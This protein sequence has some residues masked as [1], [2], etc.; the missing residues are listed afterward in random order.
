MAMEGDGNDSNYKTN[1]QSE[2]TSVL[3]AM[4]R[5]ALPHL[6]RQQRIRGG[7]KKAA[8]KGERENSLPP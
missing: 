6:R 8:N 4:R 5:V 3:A 1:R 7:Q 2:E